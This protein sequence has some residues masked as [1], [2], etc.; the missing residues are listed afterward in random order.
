MRVKVKSKKPLKT[1]EVVCSK[2]GYLLEYTGEDVKSS[3]GCYMG[4]FDI[5][6]YI[7]CPRKTCKQRIYVS[8]FNG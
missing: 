2:C 3:S 7:D 8:A 6:Y 4:E 5:S 1:K